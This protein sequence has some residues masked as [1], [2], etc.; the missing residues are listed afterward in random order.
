MSQDST[1]SITTKTDV[2]KEKNRYHISKLTLIDILNETNNDDH[3]SPKS[4]SLDSKTPSQGYHTP[5]DVTPSPPPHQ[6]NNII[7]SRVDHRE[8]S[9]KFIAMFILSALLGASIILGET[10]LKRS[11]NEFEFT[12][13]ILGLMGLAIFLYYAF[14]SRSNAQNRL[15]DDQKNYIKL[16]V[17]GSAG[18]MLSYFVTQV[19]GISPLF[20]RKIS[21]NAAKWLYKTFHTN[22]STVITSTILLAIICFYIFSFA[23]CKWQSSDQSIQERSFFSSTENSCN[24]FSDINLSVFILL[25]IVIPMSAVIYGASEGLINGW[26]NIPLSVIATTFWFAVV[27]MFLLHKEYQR[28][29]QSPKKRC[30]YYSGLAITFLILPMLAAITTICQAGNRAL[31]IHNVIS[32]VIIPIFLVLMVTGIY[33]SMFSPTNREYPNSSV[34]NLNQQNEIKIDASNQNDYDLDQENEYND[35]NTSSI[36]PHSSLP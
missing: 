22:V 17:L 36:T 32:S 28:H 15:N 18:F 10:H 33:E 20:N 8:S 21:K 16:L 6:P 1:Q 3:R 12:I 34:Y 14:K 30:L 11:F 35:K 2:I 27:C 13:A 24:M 4:K 26:I 23:Y 7:S 9:F 5:S 25:A 19:V 29:N 31:T